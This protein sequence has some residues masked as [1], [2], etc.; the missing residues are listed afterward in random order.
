VLDSPGSYA[1]TNAAPIAPI[2]PSSPD[3]K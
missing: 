3:T 2:S 1:D